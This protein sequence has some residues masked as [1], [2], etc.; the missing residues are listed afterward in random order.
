MSVMGALRVS[1]PAC[2]H[3][4]EMQA[5]ESVNADRRPDL[6]DSI[7]DGSFQVQACPCCTKAFRL[8]PK[9]NFLD[10]GRGHWISSQPLE[11]LRDWAALEDVASTIFAKAYGADAPASARQIGDKLSARLTFGWPAFREKLIIR[12]HGLDDL[13]LELTKLALIQGVGGAPLKPGL[14]FRLEAVEGD[15]WL[16]GWVD[17]QTGREHD[18]MQVPRAVYDSVVAAPQAWAE[19]RAQLSDGPFVD[20]QKL[21]IGEGRARG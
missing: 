3:D 16:M 12:D 2:G 17:G 4:F 7:L 21:F 13:T 15:D 5:A 6:R 14:E 9:F 18:V 19:L 20:I 10:V 1:C 8:D 11:Q